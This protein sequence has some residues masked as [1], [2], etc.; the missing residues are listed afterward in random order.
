MSTP[1]RIQSASD[2]SNKLQDLPAEIRLEVFRYAFDYGAR[3]PVTVQKD[4]TELSWVS[5]DPRSQLYNWCNEKLVGLNIALEAAEALYGC[6]W[7]ELAAFESTPCFIK[8][9]IAV[10]YFKPGD[11]VKNI[12]FE[13]GE[14]NFYTDFDTRYRPP[15]YEHV[16]VH[17]QAWKCLELLLEMPK[18][19][20]PLGG[21][22]VSCDGPYYHWLEKADDDPDAYEQDG[23]DESMW[24]EA[25][26]SRNEFQHSRQKVKGETC[27]PGAW[28]KLQHNRKYQG[29]DDMPEDGLSDLGMNEALNKAPVQE[30]VHADTNNE[31]SFKAEVQIEDQPDSNWERQEPEWLYDDQSFL[32]YQRSKNSWTPP[33]R[34]EKIF[35]TPT[36]DDY[37]TMRMY[38]EDPERFW[39]LPNVSKYHIFLHKHLQKPVSHKRS[40]PEVEE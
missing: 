18:H 17:P 19:S 4:T 36:T 24:S 21:R 23:D 28:L 13:I 30:H 1:E 12:S 38:D 9:S 8:S 7:F 26:Y 14:P 11:H 3:A 29:G 33:Q 37:E 16:D 31:I 25:D 34:I 5:Y 27:D 40:I 2:V 22:R 20:L 6:V 35:D 39:R 15:P 10:R 32:D